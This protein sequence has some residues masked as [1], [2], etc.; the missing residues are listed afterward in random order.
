MP[1]DVII[2]GQWGDEGKGKLVDLLAKDYSAV[3]RFSGGN[4]AGH[5]VI[6]EYGKFKLHLIPSGIL[7]PK[8]TCVIGN[9]CV[10]DPNIL[11]EEIKN[12]KESGVNISPENLIISDK[13]HI[14]LS[15]HIEKDLAQEN[16]RADFKIG[17]TGRGIGPAY[18]DKVGRSGVRMESLHQWPKWSAKLGKYIK[19]TEKILRDIL[20]NGQNIMLEGAQGALLD[21]DHGSY[22][23]V[24]SS[25]STIGG[26]LTGTGLIPADFRDI[27]GVFKAYT[28]RVGE[29]PFPTEINQLD[30]VG[31]H[32][33]EKGKEFGT[34]TGRERR[35]GWFDI[36]SAKHSIMING[37]NKIAIMKLDVLDGIEKLKVHMGVVNERASSS[38]YETITGWKESTFGITE[39]EDLPNN[40][41]IYLKFLEESLN[42][43]I[44][45]IS[46]GPE[47]DQTIRV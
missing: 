47:R 38:K 9:G 23:Y 20:N 1:A 4:N 10:I 2:G 24:T 27:L 11:I 34:T 40:A 6:N 29:G 18:M 28:T 35:C 19:S 39:Y 30:K 13:A 16:A 7:H 33:V 42:T 15:H 22:P 25:N 43:K 8:V 17:T 32:L 26:A 12:L 3:V 41:K 14:I 21:I 31:K 44:C 46:T 36:E 37:F 5:T 45:I